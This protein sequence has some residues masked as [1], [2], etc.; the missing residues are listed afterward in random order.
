LATNRSGQVENVQ[1]GT[2]F[3]QINTLF[4]ND[5]SGKFVE[6]SKLAGDGFK[7]PYVGRGVAFADLDNDGFVDVVVSN[8]GDPPSL[9]HNSGGNGNHFVNFRLLGTKSN[10]DAMGARIHVVAGGLSQIREIAGGGSYLSQSDLRANFGRGKAV[11]VQTVEINWPSGQKQVFHDIEADKFYL[12]EEGRNQLGL[13]KFS[14]KLSS[15]LPRPQDLSVADL[16]N[17]AAEEDA[18]LNGICP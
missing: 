12:I 4:H 5:G 14:R 13:Q 3:K 10:R 16:H 11:L 6:T 8:N 7:T 17:V 9:L 2:Y 18:V 1:A 15:I